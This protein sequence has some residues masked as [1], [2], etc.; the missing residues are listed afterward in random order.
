MIELL[1]LLKSDGMDKSFAHAPTIEVVL[2]MVL[3]THFIS[4]SQVPTH[5]PLDSSHVIEEA[6]LV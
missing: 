1:T 4:V 6:K 5:A 3:D 2:W